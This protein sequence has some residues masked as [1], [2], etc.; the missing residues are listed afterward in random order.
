M[1]HSRLLHSFMTQRRMS[2]YDVIM[3]VVSDKEL[4][5]F[6]FSST[7]NNNNNENDFPYLTHE[8][9]HKQKSTDGTTL[10]GALF[11]LI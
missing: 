10:S 3:C 5:F 2:Q 6:V 11:I 7:K 8:S 9:T 1:I 4:A